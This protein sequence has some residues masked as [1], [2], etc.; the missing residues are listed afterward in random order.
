MRGDHFLVN[1]G[2]LLLGAIFF[3]GVLVIA[4]VARQA[5]QPATSLNPEAVDYD[6][7]INA[8]KILMFV[9]NVGGFGRDRAHIFGYDYGTWYPYSSLEAIASNVND[10]GLKSPLY[11]AGLWIGGKVNGEV[12]VAVSEYSKEYVPGPMDRGTFVSDDPSFHVYKLYSDSLEQNPNADYLNWPVDQGAPVNNYGQPR[13]LGDQMLW[14][15]F[16]DADPAQHTN[17]AG[18]TEP[19]GIE[20]QQTV[21]AGIVYVLDSTG[22]DITQSGATE[23]QVVIKIL[24][25]DQVTGHEYQVVLDSTDGLGMIWNLI[26]LTTSTTVLANQTNFTGSETSPIVDGMQ[27]LVTDIRHTFPGWEWIGSPRPLTGVDWGGSGFFGGL[28][29]LDQFFVSDLTMEQL[30]HVEI[31]WVGEGNGQNVYLYNRSASYAYEGF[32][33]QDFEVWDVTPGWPERQIN[34]AFVENYFDLPH[35]QPD[36]LWNPGEQLLDTGDPGSF[37][38]TGGREYFQIMTSTYSEI[39]LPAYE[40][41]QWFIGGGSGNWDIL[42]GGWVCQ[43]TGTDG[44]P[45]TGDAWRIFPTIAS[46]IPDTFT[47]V[48]DI[49]PLITPSGGN[50]TTLYVAYKLYNKG[51][52]VVDSCYLAL[53]ADPDIGGSGD[54]L[55]GCDSLISCFYAYNSMNYDAQYGEAPPAIGFRIAYGP[56]VPSSG[57]TAIFDGNPLPGF[58]NLGLHSFVKY[59]N[60]TDPDNATETYRFMKG[61][62]KN[63]NPYIYNGDTTKFW[64]SGDAVIGY[65]DLDYDPADRRMMGSCGPF[66]FSPGDSQ[67]VLIRMT[68]GQGGNNLQSITVL[69]NLL[70]RPLPFGEVEDCCGRYTGGYTGNID[71]SM[72]GDITLTDITRLI[73]YVYLSHTPLCCMRN[74]NVDGSTDGVITLPDITRL[75]DKV[76]ITHSATAACQ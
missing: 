19:L 40:S 39:P 41:D 30:R 68:V 62:D 23:F 11:D 37:D 38:P 60:G 56:V 49:S 29:F 66:T 6:T 31:R 71:C 55:V 20:I 46:F 67:Y 35:T 52:N 65:G 2:R 21:W 28:G 53:W 73:D 24:N 1:I 45:D 17:L 13:M 4:A 50:V 48:T 42:Y 15:V 9:D 70:E 58:R 74:G 34:F 44:K 7:Y 27:V 57:S 16:N 69:Q 32:F 72:D 61:L 25:T 26:D 43:E 22:L 76:Y 12:R 8:N 33:P 63:G 54:D 75:I 47:F 51:E 10:A 14:S 59:I 64:C 3:T 18:E 5:H 36:S